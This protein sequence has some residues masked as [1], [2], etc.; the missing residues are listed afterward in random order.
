[1][2]VP[3]VVFAR[4]MPQHP[5][6]TAIERPVRDGHAQHISVKLEVQPVHQPQRFEL[7]LAKRAR[8]A[9]FHLIAKLR[10]ARIDDALV[11]LIVFIHQITQLPALGSAGFSV[12]SGRTVGPSA[13]TRSLMCAGRGPSGVAVASMT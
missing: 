4:D 12:R 7:I 6:L 8:Q 10:N 1:M 2:P 11:V 5:H 3:P 9:A 13:R